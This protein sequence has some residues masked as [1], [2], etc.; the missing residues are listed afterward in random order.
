[1]RWLLIPVLPVLLISVTLVVILAAGAAA[2]ELHPDR[3][4]RHARSP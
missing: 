3:A 2:V 4:Y 1:M